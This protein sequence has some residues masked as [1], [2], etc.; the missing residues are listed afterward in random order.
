MHVYSDGSIHLNHGGTEMGQGLHTKVAQVVASDFHVDLDRVKITATTTDKVPNTSPT[1]GS[2]GADLNGMAAVDAAQQIKAR[3]VDF[4]AERIM[5]PRSRCASSRGGPGRQPSRPFGGGR[6]RGLPGRVHLSAAG[7]YKTPEIH[8]DRQTGKGS[9]FYYFA[10]GAACSEV[11]VDTLTGE[12]MVDRID[13]LHD[14]GRSLNRAVDMGQVEGGFIQGMGWLTTEEL[15][16]DDQGRLRTHAPSTYKIPLV[17]GPAAHLQRRHRRLVGQRGA[18][19][20]TLE[21]ERRAAVHAGH[22][23]ARGAGMAVASVVDYRCRRG[24]TCLRRPSAC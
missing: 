15:W 6:R 13:I 7:F 19:G 23:R 16:W 14:V 3:L 12:Y 17:V 9:P 2:V 1:A 10:Y 8:W 24:S 18:D 22:L 4:V 21:G 5:L 11:A 20:G